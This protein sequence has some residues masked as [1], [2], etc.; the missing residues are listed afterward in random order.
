MDA[1]QGPRAA[2]AAALLSVLGTAGA[3]DWNAHSGAA[4][5]RPVDG[6][7]AATLSR[8][9]PMDRPVA[10]ARAPAPGQATPAQLDF[11]SF[12]SGEV[13]R[14]SVTVVPAAHIAGGDATATVSGT[15][16]FRIVSL[17]VRRGPG[18]LVDQAQ[19]RTAVESAVAGRAAPVSHTTPA[20]LES[21]A[22]PFQLPV[23]AGEV[24]ELVLEAT[25]QSEL[26]KGPSAGRYEAALLVRGGDWQASVPLR[27]RYE[28]LHLGVLPSFEDSGRE[29]L[30]TQ[31][32]AWSP[33]QAQQVPATLKLINADTRAHT[34]AVAAAG[35]PRGVGL[36]PQRI[37]V[38]GGQTL[39]V[40]LP[41]QAHWGEAAAE[42]MYGDA[43]LTVDDEGR[44]STY[45]LR[46]CL[47]P[48]SHTWDFQGVDGVHWKA[49]YTVWSD[50]NFKLQYSVENKNVAV[51]R[52]YR[53]EVWWDGHLLAQHEGSVGRL[54][55]QSHAYGFRMEALA[56][57]YRGLFWRPPT[58]NVSYS[59][60]GG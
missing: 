17:R 21:T 24:L 57:Q 28:G 59:S 8:A 20:P 35:F 56:Q 1:G 32:V 48:G 58:V 12:W 18:H 27:V 50:G 37:S 42:Y 4:A 51:A 25:A 43:S 9:V 6:A 54:G 39:S 49:H 36:A 22:P 55:T 13:R 34:V 16:P 60:V 11:G 26:F 47:L 15:G 33:G 44:R 2:V 38:P 29:L 53:I 7:S 45:P 30:F 40:P 46:F 14:L 19:A 10:A 31:P 5:T 23:K 41:F 52:R 3:I